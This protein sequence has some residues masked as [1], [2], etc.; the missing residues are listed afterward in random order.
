[1]GLQL[2]NRPR[3]YPAWSLALLFAAGLL[4]GELRRPV[5]QWVSA[6]WAEPEQ[7][8]ELT[9]APNVQLQRKVERLRYERDDL[10][11]TF[12]AISE[13]NCAHSAE[14][15]GAP[16]PTAPAAHPPPAQVAALSRE[17]P[18]KDRYAEL[19]K[20]QA[21]LQQEIEALTKYRGAP[22]HASAACR[23]LADGIVQTWLNVDYL[24]QV[25]REIA[26]KEPV[27]LSPMESITVQLR[28]PLRRLH[29]TT[30][31]LMQTADTLGTASSNS[32]SSASTAQGPPSSDNARAAL[33]RQEDA[34]SRFTGVVQRML[35]APLSVALPVP[36]TEA[37]HEVECGAQIP[38][39]AWLRYFLINQRLDCLLNQAI[40]F[41]QGSLCTAC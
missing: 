7:D 13:N 24:N 10:L 36:C 15:V 17:S 4:I 27:G 14:V 9:I 34:L 22:S 20:A 29:S 30:Y 26:L 5:W 31:K 38:L 40:Q 1:M 16:K 25:V 35:S 19:L 32:P 21:G 12:A 23:A 39:E 6:Q 2:F 8:V 37:P 41:E 28:D 33:K 18:W 11:A 3:A